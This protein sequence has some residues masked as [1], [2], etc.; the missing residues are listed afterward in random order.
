MQTIQY[1]KIDAA[2][3][4]LWSRGE[5]AAAREAKKEHAVIKGP[6]PF[7]DFLFLIKYYG[8]VSIY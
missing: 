3:Q 6:V 8:K 5:Y 4:S 2:L 7:D 1:E